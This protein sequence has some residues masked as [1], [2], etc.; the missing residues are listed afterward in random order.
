[1]LGEGDAD[2]SNSRAFQPETMLRPNR[3]LPIWSAVTICLAAKIGLMKVTWSVPN[4]TSR[5][6]AASKPDAQTMVSNDVPSVSVS[7]R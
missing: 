5:C 1:M 3:P 7:P 2:M 4:T 6:V